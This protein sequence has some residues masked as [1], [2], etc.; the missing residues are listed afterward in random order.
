MNVLRLIYTQSIQQFLQIISRNFGVM[1]CKPSFFGLRVTHNCNLK[2]KHCSAWR[3][4]TKNTDEL[5]T[6]QWKQI[7]SYIGKWTKGSYLV[8]SGGE[9]LLRKDIFELINHANNLD[10]CTIITS[11]GYA[12][13]DIARKLAESKVDFIKLSMDGCGETHAYLRGVKDAKS[14]IENL[15]KILKDH[16]KK[17]MI[18][19][20]LS[21][22]S[23]KSM[24]QIFEF[25]SQNNIFAIEFQPILPD[26]FAKNSIDWYKKSEL[27]PKDLEEIHSS[28]DKII[29]FKKRGFPVLNS[30]QHLQLM[31]Q[32]F[33][34][35]NQ[36]FINTNCNANYQ[37]LIIRPNGDIR[38]CNYLMGNIK[39]KVIKEI[40]HNKKTNKLRK[41]LKY[42]KKNCLLF[43]CNYKENVFNR[44]NKLRIFFP[45]K[46]QC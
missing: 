21:E 10:L 41:K 5:D 24:N 28:I 13:K 20:I 16:N 29:N 34:D 31:K 46:S 42:C 23:Q 33:K 14:K 6:K 22:K 15:I 4:K 43:N 39:H 3:K 27:W 32:Y 18:T 8:F 40:W 17:V 38:M 35:P 7:I 26:I 1:L 19:T 37:K 44:F 9:P 25:V 2:C 36:N 30:I 11:N 45:K 12:N